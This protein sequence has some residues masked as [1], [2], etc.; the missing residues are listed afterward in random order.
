MNNG[1]RP[2][3]AA[4]PVRGGGGNDRHDN[5]GRSRSDSTVRAVGPP[6]A[7]W[8]PERPSA[9]IPI[10][11]RRSTRSL[12]Y[13]LPDGYRPLHMDVYVPNGSRYASAVRGVDTRWRVAVRQSTDAPRQVWPE[14]ESLLD[15]DRRR[16]RGGLHRLPAFARGLLPR[17]AARCQSGGGAVPAPVRRSSS[18]S[19]ACRIGAWG[20]SAGGHLAALLGLVARPGAGRRRRACR[21]ESSAV[22]A[23]VDFYGVS[24]VDTL[25]SFL[26]SLPAEFV[27]LA[28]CQRGTAAEADPTSCDPR[29][30]P[31]STRSM[32]ARVLSPVHP[33]PGG[34]AP[35]FLLV[36]GDAE[37]PGSPSR[38]AISSSR[39][40]RLAGGARRPLHR[41]GRRPRLPGSRPA[42]SDPNRR[43]S[44]SNRLADPKCTI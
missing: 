13:S 17:T 3:R 2:E 7:T 16:T 14:G 26:D 18:A 44:S 21:G 24:D 20:E 25:P 40:S 41:R 33:C 1:D 23:V 10:G 6:C 43:W 34:V 32:L 11:A 39:R 28:P 19:I 5:R 36:H 8:L 31:R 12:T 35:P 30:H 42:S 15:G 9:S 29:P 4:S 38:R 37:G 27:A 22:A